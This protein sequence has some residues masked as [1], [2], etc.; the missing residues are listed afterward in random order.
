MNPFVAPFSA[1]FTEGFADPH[2][3]AR[4]RRP[5]QAAH[6]QARHTLAREVL[7]PRVSQSQFEAACADAVTVLNVPGAFPEQW[8]QALESA[9]SDDEQ[10]K[11]F[12]IRLNGLLH[13]DQPI[14]K[15]FDGFAAVLA[16]LDLL[17]WPMVS[18]FPALVFPDRFFLVDPAAWPSQAGLDLPARPDWPAWRQ[19]QQWAHQLKKDLAELAP[20][21]LLDIYAL[22]GCLA[23]SA[24]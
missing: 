24:A 4:I 7:S 18:V 3:Q 21:D 14:E 11:E 20:A 16:R 1:E 10:R 13:I 2:Y 8:G 9:L 22:G 5:L 12:T 17:D 19:S 23:R 6:V 15:R